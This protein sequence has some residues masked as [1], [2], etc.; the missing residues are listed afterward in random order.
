M[1]VIGGVEEK[2]SVHYCSYFLFNIL[3]EANDENQ[4]L[5]NYFDVAYFFHFIGLCTGD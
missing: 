1:H 5:Y 2:E 3:Q 4:I